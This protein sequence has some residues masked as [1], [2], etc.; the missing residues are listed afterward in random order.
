MSIRP[1]LWSYAC[2]LISRFIAR[3][4]WNFAMQKL[5]ILYPSGADGVTGRWYKVPSDTRCSGLW[6]ARGKQSTEYIT[7]VRPKAVNSMGFNKSDTRLFAN[8]ESE[9]K[10]SNFSDFLLVNQSEFNMIQIINCRLADRKLVDMSYSQVFWAERSV[11]N[12]F[13]IVGLMI[14][15]PSG[16]RNRGIQT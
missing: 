15:N 16:Q 14:M 2:S 8:I 10:A 12:W 3:M 9:I 6:K 7:S 11:E 1:D 4:T 13:L 5:Q